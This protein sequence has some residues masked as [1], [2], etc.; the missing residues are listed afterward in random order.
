ML[1]TIPCLKSFCYIQISQVVSPLDF[2]IDDAIGNILT[3][4]GIDEGDF[5]IEHNET[6][7]SLSRNSTQEEI[8]NIHKIFISG[9]NIEN[10][11]FEYDN[12]GNISFFLNMAHG[13]NYISF[14][15]KKRIY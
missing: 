7:T 13:T 5:G 11:I 3:E 4:F 15:V 10:K 12:N 2:N 6:N 1:C 9:K 8:L 14:I